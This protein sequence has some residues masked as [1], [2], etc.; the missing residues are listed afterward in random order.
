VHLVPVAWGFIAVFAAAFA[1]VNY[2]MS[3]LARLATFR[4][5]FAHLNVAIGAALISTVLVAI[6]PT[7]HVLYGAYLVAPLQ[8]AVH[9]GRRDAWG[10]L[11]INITAFALVT[12]LRTIAGDWTWSLLAQEALVLVF[13]AVA[14]IPMLSAGVERL[15]STR[16]VLARVERGDLASKVGDPELEAL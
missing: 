6:G 15:R 16:A 3:R 4:G 10:A 7:G 9:L 5:W 12:A 14:L 13:A 8:A 2:V 1:A 11:I